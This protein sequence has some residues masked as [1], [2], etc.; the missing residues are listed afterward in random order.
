MG[1]SWSESPLFS[2]YP[3]YLL[4]QLQSPRGGRRRWS[5]FSPPIH[6]PATSVPCTAESFAQWCRNPA[7]P[8]G[9]QSGGWTSPSASQSADWRWHPRWSPPGCFSWDLESMWISD[10]FSSR[11]GNT[12]PPLC[13][14][15]GTGEEGMRAFRNGVGASKGLLVPMSTWELPPCCAGGIR[16]ATGFSEE[17]GRERE[18]LVLKASPQLALLNSSG[19]VGLSSNLSWSTSDFQGLV[20]NEREN[21]HLSLLINNG[22]ASAL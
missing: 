10:G 5:F 14:C 2:I 8:G 11:R 19:Q 1:G 17:S 16:E 21:A 18:T 4:A 20:Y 15:F 7:P 22:N 12:D 6:C 9:P 3:H 13:M